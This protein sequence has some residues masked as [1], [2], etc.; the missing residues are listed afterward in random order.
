M[1]QKSRIPLAVR[2]QIDSS[3]EE[4]LSAAIETLSVKPRGRIESSDEES[5]SAVMESPQVKKAID[6]SSLAKI[7]ES[8]EDEENDASIIPVSP[9]GLGF[10]SPKNPPP[11]GQQTIT[12]FYRPALPRPGF[13]TFPPIHS[14]RKKK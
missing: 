7:D 6:E 1:F 11:P 10:K 9:K 13:L 4:D 12:N 8:N 2:N 3:A 14:P 5:F